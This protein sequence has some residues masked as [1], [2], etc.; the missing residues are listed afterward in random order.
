M[1][2]LTQLIYIKEGQE[3]VYGLHNFIFSSLGDTLPVN[4]STIVD[5]L[6]NPPEDWVKLASPFVYQF[7]YEALDKVG[8]KEDVIANLKKNIVPM[9]EKGATTLWEVFPIRILLH[10]PT[11]DLWY[12]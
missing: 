8:R 1:I 9:L 3:E 12:I 7:Y 6:L 10:P 2:Y 5:S 4:Q 11:I